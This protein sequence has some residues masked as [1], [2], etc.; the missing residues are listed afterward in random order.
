MSKKNGSTNGIQSALTITIIILMRFAFMSTMIFFP[1]KSG[2]DIV[3][4]LANSIS[5]DDP[6]MKAWEYGMVVYLME[7]PDSKYPFFS[8]LAKFQQCMFKRI[9]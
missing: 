5:S 9:R 3:S 1:H 8:R 7:I 2:V 6:I 4:L